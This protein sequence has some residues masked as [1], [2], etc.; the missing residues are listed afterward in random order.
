MAR[1]QPPR[2]YSST[3]DI[4]EQSYTWVPHHERRKPDAVSTAIAEV[5]ML[6]LPLGRSSADIARLHFGSVVVLFRLVTRLTHRSDLLV[7]LHTEIGRVCTLKCVNP[8]VM[9][10]RWR[11]KQKRKLC[12]PELIGFI[13]NIEELRDFS[14]VLITGLSISTLPVL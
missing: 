4:Y 11:K 3:S 12:V 13:Q 7:V 9:P 10:G 8:I 2:R 5:A 14:K 6:A 1:P